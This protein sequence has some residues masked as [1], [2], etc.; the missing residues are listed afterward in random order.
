MNAPF[1]V[2][3][4][5][6]FV[7]SVAA[8]GSS[9][10]LRLATDYHPGYPTTPFVLHA[11]GVQN[12]AEVCKFLSDSAREEIYLY[13]YWKDGTIAFS[14]ENGDEI[15]ISA[16]SLKGAPAEPNVEEVQRSLARVSAWLEQE[17]ASSVRAWKRLQSII[18]L[19]HE[20]RRRIEVKAHNHS[21]DSAAGIVY[22]Q[23]LRFIERLLA[24]A[25]EDPHNG[26]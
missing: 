1:E 19:L 14:T 22:G 21:T 5:E 11:E 9:L 10:Y 23:Q 12:L 4:E 15:S 13:T 26:E 16:V 3:E 25:E 6:H 7:S 24:A 2:P 17:R 18:A 8:D 20:Q